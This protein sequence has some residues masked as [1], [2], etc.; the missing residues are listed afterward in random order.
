MII[1]WGGVFISLNLENASTA[2]TTLSVL[3]AICSCDYI[4]SCLPMLVRTP[5]PFDY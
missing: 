4:S 2:P 3:E 1:G 5:Y